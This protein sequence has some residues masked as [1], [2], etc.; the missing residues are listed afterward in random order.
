M[1]LV[2]PAPL[3]PLLDEVLWLRGFLLHCSYCWFLFYA[4]FSLLVQH[5]LLSRAVAL[6]AALHPTVP[7]L[8]K[9]LLSCLVREWLS[10][11][12]CL[13]SVGAF[14]HLP[15]RLVWHPPLRDSF[16]RCPLVSVT[17]PRFVSWHC[18][19]VYHFPCSC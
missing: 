14:L 16:I 5:A 19:L 4:L 15:A 1:P 8:A 17:R 10:W 13:T 12:F 9:S 2:L 11:W 6:H 18:S 7:L 3:Y